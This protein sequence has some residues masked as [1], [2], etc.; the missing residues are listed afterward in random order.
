MH[1]PTYCKN[2]GHVAL[3]GDDVQDAL[4]W[5]YQAIGARWPNQEALDNLSAVQRGI[6]VPH[7]WPV[8]PPTSQ[9]AD[10]HDELRKALEPFAIYAE[11]VE[12]NMKLYDVN[13]DPEKILLTNGDIG[14]KDAIRFKHFTAVRVALAATERK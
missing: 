4:A 6:P 3:S 5:A 9:D 2:C 11:R 7:E 14:H 1:D 12:Q 8:V 10:A 13:L